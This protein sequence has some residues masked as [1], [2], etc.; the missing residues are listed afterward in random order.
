MWLL[1]AVVSSRVPAAAA[2]AEADQ[3]AFEQLARGDEGALAE[4]YDRHA[5]LLYSLA[6]RIVRH[7][8]DAEDVLQEVFSQAWRQASR[9]DASRGTVVGWLVTLTRARAID[10]LRKD[11]VRPYQVNDELA[12]RNLP[13]AGMSADLQLVTAEQASQVRAALEALPDTQRVPLELA[14]FEGL[15]Q[16]EIAD[17]LALPIG[18]VKTRTRQALLRL[19]EALAGQR[20]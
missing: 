17:R 16:T 8:A 10:R 20:P 11:R 3:R 18:T 19:R 2:S 14:Y 4:L 13:D 15:T 6:L 12:A 1:W 7:E 5:R 9:Y